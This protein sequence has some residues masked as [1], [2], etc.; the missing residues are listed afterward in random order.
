MTTIQDI[1]LK[2]K[3]QTH[4]TRQNRNRMVP[5]TVTGRFHHENRQNRNRIQPYR[6]ASKQWYARLTVALNFK[7]FTHSLNEYSLFYKKSGDSISLVA[8]YVDDILLTGNDI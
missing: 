8:V 5:G 6:Q 2:K 4:Q 3:I 1:E 7:G